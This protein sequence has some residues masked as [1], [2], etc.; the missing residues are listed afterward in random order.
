MHAKAIYNA[1]T[2]G[3]TVQKGGSNPQP[4]AN[5]TLLVTNSIVSNKLQR[6]YIVE[7]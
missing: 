6:Y 2:Q 3:R 1:L 7:F 4:S 5:H